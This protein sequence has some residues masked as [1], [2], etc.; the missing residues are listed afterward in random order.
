MPNEFEK[1][2][3]NFDAFRNSDS[4]PSPLGSGFEPQAAQAP[5]K[6]TSA[7][8][9]GSRGRN[10]SADVS[11]WPLYLSVTSRGAEVLC[12]GA[13]ALGG[14][15]DD[16]VAVCLDVV[17]RRRTLRRAGSTR[18]DRAEGAAARFAALGGVR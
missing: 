15:L 18:V 4:V 5:I 7:S 6:E 14:T 1:S 16:V 17:R 10:V 11:D 8:P 13:R 9:K 2:E 3:K 12:F